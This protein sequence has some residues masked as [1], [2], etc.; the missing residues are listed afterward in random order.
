M[1]A[2]WHTARLR[3]EITRIETRVAGIEAELERSTG[4]LSERT[5]GIHT[6]V[7]YRPL[8]AWADS[9]S[10]GPAEARTITF[11]Q[12][13][14]AG[15]IERVR[16]RC[17]FPFGPYRAGHYAEIDGG[18]A[19]RASVLIRRFTVTPQ[20]DGLAL[21]T[22]IRFDAR[23]QVQGQYEFPCG[24][25]VGTTVGVTGEAEPSAVFRLRLSGTEG[26]AAQYTVD[27]VSPDRI[28]VELAFHLNGFGR[29]R[30]TVPMEGLARRLTSGTIDLMYDD[31]GR[32]LLPD[33]QVVGYRIATRSP[34]LATDTTGLHF[35]TG[36]QVDIERRIGDAPPR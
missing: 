34:T 19:T 10:A 29:I 4:P 23:T 35:S 3:R 6:R 25:S 12:T 9:F 5:D 32:I 13:S 24:G 7:R 28:G 27:L 20:L 33:G 22:A 8:V 14:S 16:R 26:N 11:R 18:D 17:Q 31:E 15:Y 36:V 30:F 2:P 1:A 21:R